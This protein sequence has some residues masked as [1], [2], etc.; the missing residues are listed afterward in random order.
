MERGINLIF[1]LSLLSTPF[2]IS[3]DLHSD[4]QSDTQNN[5][6]DL[7]FFLLLSLMLKLCVF[8]HVPYSNYVTCD[9]GTEK[10]N[11]FIY[12]P[13]VFSHINYNTK[14]DE[15]KDLTTYMLLSGVTLLLQHIH[16]LKKCFKNDEQ[17]SRR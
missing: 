17:T 8:C 2:N 16:S 7:R 5:N 11:L 9:G 15:F 6:F 4:T 12:P 3:K 1:Y 14:G 13:S 10:V